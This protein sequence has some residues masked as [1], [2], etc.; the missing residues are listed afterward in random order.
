MKR[1]RATC[2]GTFTATY[3]LK[4][5]C[6]APGGWYLKFGEVPILP[7]D[8][9]F[10]KSGRFMTRSNAQ[11]MKWINVIISLQIKHYSICIYI[12][13]RIIYHILL[14]IEYCKFM[15]INPVCESNQHL[16]GC[17]VLRPWSVVFCPR[18]PIGLEHWDPLRAP[19]LTRKTQICC[20]IVGKSFKKKSCRI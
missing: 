5:V 9:K 20:E 6:I 16:M 19:P 3:K 7:G 13:I 1:S 15:Y 17:F 18:P 14:Y 10:T 2:M 8:W 4:H 12:Y 11:I